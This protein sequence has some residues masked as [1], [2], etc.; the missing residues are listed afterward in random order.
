VKLAFEFQQSVRRWARRL[1]ISYIMTIKVAKLIS[2]TSAS[3]IVMATPPSCSNMVTKQEQQG[4][5]A[6]P[7]YVAIHIIFYYK[8]VGLS[9][10]S[11]TKH[12]Y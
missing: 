5:T 9:H 11:P 2:N 6:L 7:A 4:A 10:E 8:S 1:R 12:S 3:K